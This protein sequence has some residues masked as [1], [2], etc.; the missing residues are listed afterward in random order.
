MIEIKNKKRCCACHACYNICPKKAI[1]MQR[2]EKGFEYPV[3][4]K[5][6][7]IQCNLCS[8]VC[9]ISSQRKSEK[10]YSKSYAVINCD[11]KVR[12][13]SSS[14]GMFTALANYIIGQGGI[15]FGAQFDEEYNVIHTYTD[16]IEEISLYRGS[17]Y[18]QSKIGDTY[19]KVK[20]FLEEDKYVLFTGTPC[21][22]AGLRS[23]LQK[24]YSKLYLQDIICHGVPSPKVWRKYLSYRE[25]KEENKI[26]NIKFRNKESGWKSYKIQISYSDKEYI[27]KSTEDIY[28]IAFL[29][30]IILRDS[31]YSCKF[32]QKHRISDITLADFWGVQNI[33]PEMDDDKGTS[34]VIIHSHKGKEL[35]DQIKEKIQYQEVDLEIA[36]NYN[37]SM[38]QPAFLNK[39]REK[40]FSELEKKDLEDLIKQYNVAP[41]GIEKIKR[42]IYR[43]IRLFLRNNE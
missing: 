41:N 6:K 37:P 28:M 13:E 3:I 8:R 11:Q 38:I 29:K 5:E 18:V 26:R 1:T 30:D 10:Q 24:E 35:F 23:F 42:K 4:D 40:F 27:K 31:C 2:D 9:P 39:N 15:V 43:K 17:K 25:Q 7:C 12:M 22:I 20:Q 14:G 34:L 32:K 21:Q 33:L 19:Q 16:K 36:S